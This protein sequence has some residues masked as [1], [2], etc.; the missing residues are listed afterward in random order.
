MIVILFWMTQVPQ[1]QVEPWKGHIDL[2]LHSAVIAVSVQYAMDMTRRTRLSAGRVSRRGA[3]A[4]AGGF[5]RT[6][7]WIT[8]RVHFKIGLRLDLGAA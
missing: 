8:A 1:L 3:K 6:R 7:A 4:V 5:R 2:G